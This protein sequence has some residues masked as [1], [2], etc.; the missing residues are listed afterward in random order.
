[1]KIFFE[2]LEKHIT[3]NFIEHLFLNCY[4]AV[5]LLYVITIKT[6]KYITIVIYG[7]LKANC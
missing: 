1:M 5:R 4:I 7:A 6:N 3:K 2:A